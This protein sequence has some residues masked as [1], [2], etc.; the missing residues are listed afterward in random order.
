MSSE[1]LDW[2]GWIKKKNASSDLLNQRLI[3][4]Y[5]FSFTRDFNM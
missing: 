5:S 1:S 3:L 4:K 2:F